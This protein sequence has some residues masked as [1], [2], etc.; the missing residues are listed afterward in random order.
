MSGT[1]ACNAALAGAFVAE[2]PRAGLRHA[3]VCPGSRSTPLA[4]ALAEAGAIRVWMHADERS[5]AFFALGMA[6]ALAEPVGVLCSSGTAAANFLPAVVEAH[7]S[8]V[9]LLVLTADRPPELRDVGAAQTIDQARLYGSHA[10]WFYELPVPEATADLLRHA[11]QVAA[12]AIATASAAPRGPV[13][14]NF[15]F[16]EPLLPAPGEPAPAIADEAA[17]HG[18]ADDAPFTAVTPSHA[19][20]AL[21]LAPLARDLAGRPRGLIVCGPQDDPALAPAVTALAAQFGYPVLADALSQ[22]R[23]GPHDR[24]LVIDDYDAF[25]RADATCGALAPDVVLRFGALPTSK[26]L[27]QFLAR[28]HAGRHILVDDGG[29]RDPL[30]LASDLIQADPVAVC[31]ALGAALPERATASAWADAWRAAAEHARTAMAACLAAPDGTIEGRVFTE[32]AALLP[33][34]ATIFAGNSMPVRDLDTFLPA[35]DH[36][37]R[38]LANRGANGI[39]GVVSSALGVAAV[40]PEPVVLVLGDLSFYH[41]LNGLLAAKLHGLR[42]TIVVV[43]NDGGG[44]FS[45]LPQASQV[46]P[47]RFETLFGTPLGLDFRAAADLY[48]ARFS[49]PESWEDF[50]AAVVSGIAGAGLSIVEVRSE[51]AANVTQHRVVWR[52]VAAA[53]REPAAV[54]GA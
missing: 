17:L 42:A 40:S 52:A 45:F 27:A 53:L 30:F 15:P 35:G 32:L 34:G 1:G 20:P 46:A 49:R 43:N 51:R 23:R 9:P 54:G 16:R 3:V 33:A 29:W 4:V 18:R 26:P 47:A 37:L 39:D 7:L 38:C 13:H 21:D 11:R 36:A 41:D 8:R 25:L 12:R 19:V 44:I 5:A 6:R 22:V 48:G 14:L 50:R 24:A 31:A 10:K 28:D 2:L